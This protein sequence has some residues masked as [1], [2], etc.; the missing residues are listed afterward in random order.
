MKL[1]INHKKHLYECYP[2]A[3]EIIYAGKCCSV[4]EVLEDG[5]LRGMTG[6]NPE[7]V[8]ENAVWVQ[9]ETFIVDR[10][11]RFNA[12]DYMAENPRGQKYFRGLIE[13][14]RSVMDGHLL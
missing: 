4:Y 11:I 2:Q 5:F 7:L 10:L 3:V 12:L 13:G 9:K 1:V 14:L 6:W 8:N